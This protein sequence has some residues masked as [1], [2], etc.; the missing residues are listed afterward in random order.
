[1]YGEPSWIHEP[2]LANSNVNLEEV[3]IT[4]I[5][6]ENDQREFRRTSTSISNKVLGF[7][8]IISSITIIV[9]VAVIASDITFTSQNWNLKMSVK[10][11]SLNFYSII[12]CVMIFCAELDWKQF[13][14]FFGFLDSW[15]A[16][17]LFYV[18]VAVL[19][20]EATLDGNI[21]CQ[22]TNFAMLGVGVLYFLM[23]I[24]CLKTVKETR[25][26]RMNTSHTNTS[27]LV[28]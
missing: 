26:R 28:A 22:I 21:L 11:I 5:D 25:Q 16:K 20:R 3:P 8:N 18:F 23:G 7:F 10:E 12:F 1:M 6:A 15:T 4:T 9:A 14:H 27:D 13:L 17:G 19:T 24:A 2:P